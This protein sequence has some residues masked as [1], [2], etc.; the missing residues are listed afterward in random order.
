MNAEAKTALTAQELAALLHRKEYGNET[1]TTLETLAKEA[2]L[3]I[4]FG[5]SDDNCEF[6]GAINEEIPCYD[7]EDIYFNKTGTNFTN[8]F[9][10]AFLT[11]HEDKSKPHKNHIRAVWCPKDEAGKVYASWIYET[12]IPHV[13][14]DVLE[15]DNLYCRGIVFSLSDLN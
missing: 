1:T 11:Y 5:Y 12:K 3:A 13:T 6:R 15:D 7:G 4:V 14:F 8:N 10:E 9:G 2:G